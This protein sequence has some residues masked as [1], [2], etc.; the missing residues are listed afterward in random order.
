MAEKSRLSAD[1]KLAK[2]QLQEAQK[3]STDLEN[4]LQN[5]SKASESLQQ[6]Q[7]WIQ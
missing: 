4:K 7:V 5:A 1:L 3:K 6:K 2:T